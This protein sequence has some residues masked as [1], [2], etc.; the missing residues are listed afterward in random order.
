MNGN[1]N[2]RKYR[3]K[4][5]VGSMF[6][7]TI[8]LFNGLGMFIYVLGQQVNQD[9]Y[10][11]EAE[12]ICI[13]PGIQIV[14][15]PDASENS[16]VIG[17]PTATTGANIINYIYNSGNGNQINPLGYFRI[18]VRAKSLSPSTLFVGG[19]WG[20]SSFEDSFLLTADYRWY[21]T[22]EFKMD[23]SSFNLKISGFTFTEYVD[24]VMIVRFRDLQ[25]SETN[26][27]YGQIVDSRVNF[28]ITDGDTDGDGLLDNT[29]TNTNV[30]WYEAE[31]F[32][33]PVTTIEVNQRDASNSKAIR[34]V[35]G[36]SNFIPLLLSSSFPNVNIGNSYKIYVRAKGFET[37]MFVSA[38]Q[39][40]N[41]HL[42][43]HLIKVTDE[44]RWYCT[45]EFQT[46]MNGNTKM[47]FQIEVYPL[48]DGPT[49]Y[50]DKLIVICDPSISVSP[51]QV[52]DPLDPDTDFDMRSDSS[53]VGSS[54]YWFEAE[55][56]GA[57]NAV[58]TK[59][60][61]SSNGKEMQR[62]TSDDKIIDQNI[63]SSYMVSQN[64]YK[65]FIR[66]RTTYASGCIE[67]KTNGNLLNQYELSS[68]YRWF[69]SYDI[70]GK[71]TVDILGSDDGV[72]LDKVMLVDK[73][74]FE[75]GQISD[76]LDPDI[77]WD[78]LMDGIEVNDNLYWFEA[79]DHVHS[80]SQ[81]N[82]L[83]FGA[84]NSADVSTILIS[85]ED[86]FVKGDTFPSLSPGTYRIFIRAKVDSYPGVVTVELNDNAQPPQTPTILFTE[87]LTVGGTYK[88]FS[89][90][91][92]SFNSASYYLNIKS[93]AQNAKLDKIMIYHTGAIKDGECPTDV[94]D[95]DIDWDNLIDGN[96][97]DENIY[98]YEAEQYVGSGATVS[99]SNSA[100]NNQF[101]TRSSS[102]A[103]FSITST[104]PNGEYKYYIRA[105]GT[106]PLKVKVNYNGV[107]TSCNMKLGDEFRWMER[108]G[109][110]EM[111]DQSWTQITLSAEQ[112]G[113]SGSV[114]VDKVL[115]IR[116]TD[117]RFEPTGI[118]LGSLTESFSSGI[119][120]ATPGRVSDVYDADTDYDGAPDG[121]EYNSMEIVLEN[122]KKID[123]T[124]DPLFEDT[125]SDGL[126]DSVELG[127][128]GIDADNGNSKTDPSCADTD[129]DHIPDGWID[130]WG[131]NTLNNHF[132]FKDKN[133]QKNIGLSGNFLYIEGEDLDLDGE[134]SEHASTHYY[135]ETNPLALDTDTDL[136][137]DFMEYKNGLDPL[138]QDYDDDGLSD[139][140]EYTRGLDPKDNDYDDDGLL[141]GLECGITSSAAPDNSLDLDLD[142]DADVYG[143]GGNFT[144]DQNPSVASRTS[145]R[146]VDTDEDGL[147]DYDEEYIIGGNTPDGKIDGDTNGDCVWDKETE[148]WTE[149]DPN[150]PDTD[151]GGIYDGIEKY[152]DYTLPL[153][154]DGD[155]DDLIDTDNDGLADVYEDTHDINGDPGGDDVYNEDY[156]GSDYNDADGDTDND[157]IG[158]AEEYVADTERKD[159]DSDG[160]GIMDG[161]PNSYIPGEKNWNEDNDHD[162]LIN[163]LDL[164]SDNDGISDSEE[165]W[166]TFR[167]NVED[168]EYD[169]DTPGKWIAIDENVETNEYCIEGYGRQEE[170]NWPGSC[171]DIL[172]YTPEGFAVYKINSYQVY[173]HISSSE[174]PMYSKNED[175]ADDAVTTL[176]PLDSYLFHQSWFWHSDPTSDDSDGDGLTDKQEDYYG[177]NP[178]E[179]DTD[180]DLLDDLIEISNDFLDPLVADMDPDDDMLNTEDELAIGTN[181]IYKDTD[182]DGLFDGWEYTYY[183]KD[184]NWMNPLKKDSDEDSVL[185]CYETE[186][187]TNEQWKLYQDDGLSNIIEYKLGCNVMNIDS[188]GDGWMDGD[189]YS[190]G[191]DPTVYASRPD[192]T[193]GDGIGPLWDPDD[194]NDGLTDVFEQAWGLNTLDPDHD[195]DL[196]VD[197]V[198][199]Q[200]DLAEYNYWIGCGYSVS[201]AVSRLKTKDS[202]GDG[203]WDGKENSGLFLLG[204]VNTKAIAF[205]SGPGADPTTM[206]M[207]NDEL[208]MYWFDSN[209][210]IHFRYF[211][212]HDDFVFDDGTEFSSQDGSTKEYEDGK[213]WFVGDMDGDQVSEVMM[214]WFDSSD[215]VHFRY[216]EPDDF[217]DTSTYYTEFYSTDG[218]YCDY[219]GEGRPK[220][221]FVGD[222]DGDGTDDVVWKWFDQN[223]ED[224]YFSYHEPGTL[225]IATNEQFC[226]TDGDCCDYY[227]SSVTKYWSVGNLDSDVTS[228]VYD[229][230][231]NIASENVYFSCWNPTTMTMRNQFQFY[232]TDAST[233][234]E[235]KDN[236]DWIEGDLD[237]NGIDEVIM[238]WIDSNNDIIFKGFAPSVFTD[239]NAN[240]IKGTTG[241]T[242][243]YDHYWLTGDFNDIEV[244]ADIKHTTN[245]LST[246]EDYPTQIPDAEVT[247]DNTQMGLDYTW[248]W[249]IFDSSNNKITTNPLDGQKPTFTFNNPGV[250]TAK[251]YVS[252]GFEGDMDTIQI[253]VTA[254]TF[255]PNSEDTDG[256]GLWDGDETNGM[257][258]SSNPYYPGNPDGYITSA[259]SPDSDGDGTTDFWELELNSR[260]G[261][262]ASTYQ[263]ANQAQGKCNP[264]TQPNRKLGIEIDYTTGNEPSTSS[265][266]DPVNDPI[267]YMIAYYNYLDIMLDCKVDDEITNVLATY[268]SNSN[269]YLDE[270]CDTFDGI[271][272]NEN[273]LGTTQ[274]TE[275]TDIKDDF[276][277]NTDYIWVYY[278]NLDINTVF[279]P[280]AWPTIGVVVDTFAMDYIIEGNTWSDPN[281]PDIPPLTW[282]P[283]DP[284]DT[285]KIVLTHEVGHCLNVGL[286]NDNFDASGNWETEEYTQDTWSIMAGG[287]GMPGNIKLFPLY[288]DDD[289]DT[290]NIDIRWSTG[291]E[292][293]P[294]TA[295][296]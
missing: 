225:T 128:I 223:N 141:D 234:V 186:D 7:L 38:T 85:G 290:H 187:M 200:H 269:G 282:D 189:E 240:N 10:V 75:P 193:D 213:E 86:Q 12:Q 205:N 64:I 47:D 252:N 40:T 220:E 97:R 45:P 61:I 181:P 283:V 87:D 237:G 247:M 271:T 76:V 296:K 44:Y 68:G 263:Y 49:L 100:S 58:E 22:R 167:T 96:E 251:V 162:G 230:F 227:G 35:Y 253:T 130:G 13:Q 285:E 111:D 165:A 152:V 147:S 248:S 36:S 164:D 21:I 113:D 257:K 155:D 56:I 69:M 267:D 288:Y 168:G 108:N 222:M 211:S 201:E 51:G 30:W 173:I 43:R 95:P 72:R 246:Y 26:V 221:W 102:G 142:Y 259:N 295:D 184:P 217:Y 33:D 229:R 106:A 88:W 79:E 207:E 83:E 41:Q 153:F 276:H 172:C 190:F 170:S 39:G 110:V 4:I 175:E 3:K 132:E 42:Y 78:E 171:P 62:R 154:W 239:S 136:V 122:N 228:E 34:P 105:K 57:T 157:G 146:K 192:D 232:S 159:P 149:C 101:S 270:Y 178:Y 52:S 204:S 6:V 265:G 293:W 50:V 214:K 174:K 209:D 279:S 226:S 103:V 235:Y 273:L 280:F 98:R 9:L 233:T 8:F 231:Y 219:I 274:D 287:D 80:S 27:H 134:I 203:L 140:N 199:G 158:D 144:G 84:S 119:Y 28:Q 131:F 139:G 260:I 60:F 29:E 188:D 126:L 116:I 14:M 291:R 73:Q 53:E 241:G 109:V 93:Q 212:T 215:D 242:V 284:E 255:N 89:T 77:D 82:N 90:N 71:P 117:E 16:A 31:H 11:D 166:I 114:F 182:Q 278:D 191:S 208:V 183:L 143:T 160:D 81:I 150:N 236:R 161:S 135:I 198:N 156:D 268:D 277:D 254:T 258:V 163:A 250:Y 195:N 24:K 177:T 281:F 249:E 244:D 210:D 145:P 37:T 123:V 137:N 127:I 138:D 133:S 197:D 65:I 74:V 272:F 262:T 266:F 125:D 256:D 176:H 120:L 224:I 70:T 129:M 20:S 216:Y 238:Y 94:M 104:L 1:I 92:F 19:S 115:F 107:T 23:Q 180:G 196:W 275:L 46:S 32:R 25:L 118:I 121:A 261:T 15:D 206:N 185:D 286:W 67:I 66:A 99:D 194:D 5:I 294:T 91:E 292:K 17:D 169:T 112:D 243:G 218:I 151:G 18:Y 264:I 48:H 124:S 63:L 54:I 55:D 59:N 245:Q 148:T 2:I 179:C 289:W 202:D